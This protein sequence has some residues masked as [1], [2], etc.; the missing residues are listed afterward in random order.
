MGHATRPSPR[1]AH[2]G[3]ERFGGDT[4]WLRPPSSPVVPPLPAERPDAGSQSAA[5]DCVAARGAL[6][7]SITPFGAPD[8]R[9]MF[10]PDR[11]AIEKLDGA[12]VAP[13]YAPS[14]PLAGHQ[15]HTPWDPLHRAYFNGEAVWTY[16]TTPFLLV[17]DGVRVE[18]DRGLAGR[19]GDL[20]RAARLLPRLDGNPLH[21]L[22][23]SFRR[24]H[25]AA[26]SRLQ[27]EHRGRFFGRPAHVWLYRSGWHSFR[28]A[29]GAPTPEVL[30]AAPSRTCCCWSRS[31]FSEVALQV[32]IAASG[33]Y[34]RQRYHLT[35]KGRGAPCPCFS[36]SC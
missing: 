23:T 30:L 24:G 11:I 33:V 26:P 36:F 16:L 28:R 1:L 5:H 17:M 15:M 27:R 3:L 2:G 25:D 12:L 14:D 18:D 7:V 21:G 19:N 8:Q 20:A 32:I 13:R 22:R 10:T 9:T 31:I 6:F 34:S 4:A 29:Y 35:A